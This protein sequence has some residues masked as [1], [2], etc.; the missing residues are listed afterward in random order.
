MPTPPTHLAR[1]R[2]DRP[3]STGEFRFWSIYVDQLSLPHAHLRKGRAHLELLR[4]RAL[5]HLLLSSGMSKAEVVSL[6]RTHIE[7]AWD[8]STVI[9]GRG[10]KERP[11]FWDAETR[12]ALDAWL[13]PRRDD[14]LPLFI[15]LDN[16]RG[17]PGRHG[18]RWRLSAQNVWNVVTQY[19]R[20]LGI[21]ARP[22]AF[23]HAMASAMLE[24]DAP[25]SLVQELLGHSSSTVTRQAYAPYDHHSLRQD[26]DRLQGRRQ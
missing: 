20:P 9:E 25:M 5:M 23:R 12:K 16:H 22:Q 2:R 26:F 17:A 8:D 3:S 13:A 7:D 15:R 19:G 18:E 21:D 24:N 4:D 14:Y 6:D 11:V 1:S 10:R